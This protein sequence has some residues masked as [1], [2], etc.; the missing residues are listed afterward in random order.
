MGKRIL[1]DRRFRTIF[2]TSA[3]ASWDIVYALF[4]AALGAFYQSFW[5]ASMSAYYVI[6]GSMGIYALRASRVQGRADMS[7]VSKRCGYGTILLAI[8][9]SG[10]T[11]MCIAETRNSSYHMIVMIALAAYAF[12]AA[13]MSIIGAVRA[14]KE[15]QTQRILRKLSLASTIGSMLLLEFSMLGTFGDP[16]STASFAMEVA[17]GAGA[18]IL[19]LLLAR[20]FIAKPSATSNSHRNRK[21]PN[22]SRQ[23]RR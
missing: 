19:L 13:T 2:T 1:R 20:S 18:C 4:N 23:T 10:V 15:S 11:C 6:L 12:Y 7:K 9:V 21:Q 5:F 17:T 16:T 14:R 8:V 3:S 22:R